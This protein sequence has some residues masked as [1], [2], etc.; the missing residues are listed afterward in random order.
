LKDQTYRKILVVNP[1]VSEK[2]SFYVN[3]KNQ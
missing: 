1:S 3:L 2:W